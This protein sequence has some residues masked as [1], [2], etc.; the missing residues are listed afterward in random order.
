MEQWTHNTVDTLRALPLNL[1]IPSLWPAAQAAS[2]GGRVLQWRFPDQ[3]KVNVLADNQGFVA[4]THRDQGRRVNARGPS[5]GHGTLD[6][7]MAV[8]GGTFQ[9]ALHRLSTWHPAALPTFPPRPAEISAPQAF[10]LP[11]RDFN[12][13]AN[14]QQVR[15]YLVQVRGLPSWLVRAT[16]DAQQV[17]AGWGHQAG[18]FLVFPCR[19]WDQTTGLRHGPDATGAIL[20]WARPGAP[21]PTQYFGQ[22]H[23][24]AKGSRK[25]AGWWQIGTGRRA[26][27]ATEAPIDALTVYAGLQ[28]MRWEHQVTV[29]AGGGQGGFL[30]RQ[31][32]GFPAVVVATDRDA[33]GDGFEAVIR[34][35]VAP[36]QPVWRLRPPADYKDWNEAWQQDRS[37]LLKVL[38]ATLHGVWTAGREC[39]ADCER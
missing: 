31:W 5:H 25:E 29:V 23:L 21:L 16:Y 3:L 10:Q 11:P 2:D 24:M 15:H 18:G 30:P 32:A 6:L 12:S 1:V 22:T 8:E 27:V 35:Q 19:P 34:R 4:W 17:Y 39:Q 37:R 14:W 38:Q 36:A 13:E 9:T 33:A 20:R 26:V 7:V 28:A